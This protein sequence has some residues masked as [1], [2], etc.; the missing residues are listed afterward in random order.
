MICIMGGDEY[1][2]AEDRVLYRMVT[3]PQYRASL[4][5]DRAASS[6]WDLIGMHLKKT[7]GSAQKRFLE[8]K[9]AAG[10]ADDRSESDIDIGSLE[11]L[12]K[13]RERHANQEAADAVPTGQQ[14]HRTQ[15]HRTS[16]TG[17]SRTGCSRRFSHVRH[18]SRPWGWWGRRSKRRGWHREQTQQE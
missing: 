14:P 15:P 18:R 7:A 9:D 1:T 11:D 17:H 6:D 16:R 4:V 12:L 5:G 3:E 2:F 13:D 10:L 8:L